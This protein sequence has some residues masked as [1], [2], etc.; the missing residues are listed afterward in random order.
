MSKIFEFSATPRWV[1]VYNFDEK[2]VFTGTLNFFV[3]PHTG[4]PACCTTEKC[5]PKAGKA[6]VWNGEKW[7]YV[8]D[9]RGSEY[10]DTY[11]RKNIM[12]DVGP[13]PDD[14]TFTP[15]N[16][17]FDTWDGEKWVTDEA[18]LH[19]AQVEAARVELSQR[20]NDANAALAPLQDAAELQEATDEEK[21]ALTEWK[22]YR[23]ALSRI[24]INQAPDIDW[25]EIP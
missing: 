3:A 23:L 8:D 24:D 7:Q 12:L 16:T 13:L 20:V 15:P 11:G 19:A 25:P 18:K 21:A 2:N 9:Y 17:Q 6:G 5:A 14:C 22:K 10:W 1:W 4:L